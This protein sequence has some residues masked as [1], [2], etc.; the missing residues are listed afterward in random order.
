MTVLDKAVQDIL[1]KAA[2][3]IIQE[4]KAN[5]KDGSLKNSL[6]YQL[7]NNTID[8]IMAEYGVFYDKGVSGANHSDFNGKKK[9]IHKSIDGYKFNGSKGAI[10]GYKQIDRWMSKNN[11]APS[12]RDGVN[13]AIRRSIHHHGIK[14]SLF[15]TTPYEK[16]M[17]L[18]K[19]EFNR[20]ALQINQ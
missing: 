3:N 15:L 13:F 6:K 10:G 2:E 4:A 1:V 5:L 14:P 12:N 18:I 17:E 16:Y 8:I 7:N 11:V 19:G 20:L 9:T